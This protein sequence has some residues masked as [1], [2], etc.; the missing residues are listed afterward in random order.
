[1]ALVNKTF[2][3]WSNHDDFW[4]GHC[5]HRWEDKQGLS[6]LRPCD[7]WK[8]RYAW[9]EYDKYRT[10]ITRDEIS[11]YK[12]KLI[13]NGTESRMGLRQFLRDGTFH[14]PYAGRCE[15]QLFGNRMCFMGIELAVERNP[16]NWGWIIGR[17]RPTVYYSIE[18]K[19]S[20]KKNENN[21]EEAKAS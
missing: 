16:S 14:S 1:M 7:R 13:Y 8:Q 9:A 3:T 17:G 20:K 6:L 5:H 18:E 12:W 15:W 10:T 4:K 2:H 21:N 11:Y 19:S